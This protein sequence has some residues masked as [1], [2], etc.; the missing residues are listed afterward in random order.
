MIC[1]ATDEKYLKEWAGKYAACF[2]DKE[3]AVN[4]GFV[5]ALQEVAAFDGPDVRAWAKS[6]EEESSQRMV[7]EGDLFALGEMMAF[8]G[9]RRS[10]I[11]GSISPPAYQEALMGEGRLV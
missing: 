2:A 10:E 8:A 4:R 6:C 9:I 5:E 1:F 3:D 11:A 7:D